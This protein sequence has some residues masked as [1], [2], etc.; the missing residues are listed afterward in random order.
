MNNP[1]KITLGAKFKAAGASGKKVHLIV[2]EGKW[3]V[4]LKG[5]W[6]NLGEYAKK[7]DAATRAKEILKFGKS[8]TLVIHK[9]NGK[10][11]K[12]FRVSP[13]NFPT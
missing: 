11:E 13:N 3:I 10:V 1:R 12:V 7:A 8:E 2:R 6:G 5:T 9:P 4:F